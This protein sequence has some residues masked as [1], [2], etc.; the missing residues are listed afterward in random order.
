MVAALAVQTCKQQQQRPPVIVSWHMPMKVRQWT[1]SSC[2]AMVYVA[3]L[4][5]FS[6]AVL[7][8]PRRRVAHSKHASSKGALPSCRMMNIRNRAYQ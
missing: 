7:I 4:Q 3:W 8:L 5:Y 6:R 1:D 2:C